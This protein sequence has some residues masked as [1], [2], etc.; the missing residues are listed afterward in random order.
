M[1][2]TCGGVLLEVL[3]Y[4]LYKKREKIISSDFSVGKYLFLLSMPV[5]AIAAIGFNDIARVLM[6]FLS[7]AAVGTVL[8]W[9]IGFSYH[10]I[11]GKRLWTYHHLPVHEYT[12]YLSI[13]LWG[14]AG[15]LFWLLAQV[16]I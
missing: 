3:V 12:S 9:L 10:A 7:F 8:E 1:S 11:M 16:F 6:V 2:L 13:P 15:I 14:L 5:M 4:S